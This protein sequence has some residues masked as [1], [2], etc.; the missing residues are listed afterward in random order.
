MT[1]MDVRN[2]V[3]HIFYLIHFRR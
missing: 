2:V 1:D 3:P